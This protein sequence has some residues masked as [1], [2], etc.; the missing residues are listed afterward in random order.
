VDLLKRNSKVNAGESYLYI[1]SIIAYFFIFTYTVFNLRLHPNA[2]NF[3]II[4]HCVNWYIRYLD[5]YQ[6]EA[7]A[8][9]RF[10]AECTVANVIVAGLFG[11][12]IMQ[13]IP[14]SAYFELLFSQSSFYIWA[15]MHYAV[16][17]RKSDLGLWF[18][19]RTR[20]ET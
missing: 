1:V 18:P 19:I 20:G 12:F 11:V 2:L 4:T 17:Y 9:R 13:L 14:G 3:I 15:I 8:Q 10:V 7:A 6:N 5:R 16:T